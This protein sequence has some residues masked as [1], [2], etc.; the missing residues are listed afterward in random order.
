MADAVAA[1]ASVPDGS[2]ETTS[3]EITG[4]GEYAAFYIGTDLITGVTY[5]ATSDTYTITGLSQ[6]DLDDL[7]FVQAA[8]AL[9]DQDQIEV[10]AWTVE[11]GNGAELAR[12]TDTVTLSVTP[13][14][15]TTGNDNLIWDGQAINGRAGTDTVALR[16]GED[17]D[18]SDLA[19]LLQNV[20]VLDLSVPGSNSITGGLSI[21]DVL[22]ITGSNTGTLT[23]D[24][25]AED[26][27]ELSSM[28][29]WT[30]NGVVVDGHLVYTNTSSGVTLSI[31]EDINVSYAA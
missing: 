8:S 1:S 27:V 28:D 17:L 18:H 30:T 31:D 22:A 21:S 12:V 3:M 14:L 25:D 6:D 24:G 23:I 7:G 16:Y 29:E 9:V 13:T 15:A 26:S 4:L 2:T 5:D 19:S 11:S 20:E 10:T